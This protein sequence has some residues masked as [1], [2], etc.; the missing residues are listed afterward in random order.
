MSWET[1]SL[2]SPYPI[3]FVS[4]DG[5]LDDRGFWFQLLL[6][7]RLKVVTPNLTTRINWIYLKISGFSWTSYRRKFQRNHDS[8]IW[9]GGLLLRKTAEGHLPREGAIRMTDFQEHF[10]DD[11]GKWLEMELGEEWRWSRLV[12]MSISLWQSK[13]DHPCGLAFFLTFWSLASHHTHRC[14]ATCFEVLSRA[15]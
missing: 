3:G 6:V 11:S 15:T 9:R 2:I 10:G 5:I 13:S 12:F 1:H 7:K 14:D 4:D 8:K